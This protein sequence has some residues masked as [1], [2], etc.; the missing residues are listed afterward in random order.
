[1]GGGTRK[2][3]HSVAGNTLNSDEGFIKQLKE[4]K[5]GLKEVSTVEECDFILFFCPIVSRPEN[6]IKSALQKLQSLSDT[7]PAVVVVLHH[8]IK[9]DITLPQ[10]GESV[11]RDNTL[12]VDCVFHEDRGLLD[13]DSN[14]KALENCR[15]WIKQNVLKSSKTSNKN[16]GL[17][18]PKKKKQKAGETSL[19]AGRTHTPERPEAESPKIQ[20]RPEARSLK[21]QDRPEEESPKMQ[22]KPEAKSTEM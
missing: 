16:P 9:P 19:S 20:H 22:D 18:F 13:C 8:T 1:M 5:R 2:Y 4:R 6:D 3:F 14:H 10:S 15:L 17:N 7:K 11:N 12:T 21:T